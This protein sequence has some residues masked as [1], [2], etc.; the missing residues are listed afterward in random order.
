MR[1]WCIGGL[2]IGVDNN[3]FYVDCLDTSCLHLNE[4]RRD[5]YETRIAKSN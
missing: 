3:V 4:R 2:V 1:R 5:H